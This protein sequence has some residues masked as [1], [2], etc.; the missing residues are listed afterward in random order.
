MSSLFSK[1][2]YTMQQAPDQCFSNCG[3]D[4]EGEGVEGRGVEEREAFHTCCR[5]ILQTR[6]AKGLPW[7]LRW[8]RICPQWA[9]LRL[10][11]WVR[12]I[13]WRR[14]WLPTLILRPGEFHE[15]KWK[16]EPRSRLKERGR[17]TLT[18]PSN[19]PYSSQHLLLRKLQ[20]LHCLNVY[21]IEGCCFSLLPSHPLSLSPSAQC[22][23]FFSLSPLLSL[24]LKNARQTKWKNNSFTLILLHQSWAIFVWFCAQDTSTLQ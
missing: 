13:P 10:D 19:F 16:K 14:E 5:G 9:R 17:P 8:Q 3:L 7:W 20:K 21:S 11:P 1:L 23:P 4:L 6:P 18:C 12:K 2:D 24:P 22:P 15:Q